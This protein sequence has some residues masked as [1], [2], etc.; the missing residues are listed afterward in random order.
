MGIL[1]QLAELLIS[2]LPTVIFVFVLFILLDRFFYRPLAAVMKKREKKT[3]GAIARAR[4]QAAEADEKATQ[5]EAAFQVARQEVYRQRE[6]ARRSLLADREGTLKRAQ[7]QSE[8]LINEAQTSLA[9]EV[10]RSK[11]DLLNACQSLGR[12]IAETILGG[13]ARGREEG[14]RS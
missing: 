7:Q 9:A 11:T 12:E 6:A 14:V 4:E 8:A 1:S 13:A 3:T 5:Y 2:T 10:A